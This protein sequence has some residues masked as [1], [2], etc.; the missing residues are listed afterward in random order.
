MTRRTKPDTLLL[1]IDV[2]TSTIKVGLYDTQGNVRGIRRFPQRIIRPEPCW[3][4]LDPS[5]WWRKICR[6]VKGLLQDEAIRSRK[7]AS[8]GLSGLCPCAMLLDDR[9]HAITPAIFHQD[10]RGLAIWRGLPRSTLNQAYRITGN[11][12]LPGTASVLSLLWFQE[13]S[14]AKFARAAAFGHATTLLGAKLTGTLGIDGSQA[15]LSGLFD[16]RAGVWS[17]E[18]CA[19]FGVE[20]RLLPPLLPA[21]ARLG[22]LSPEAARRLGLCDGIPVCIGGADTACAALGLGK[23]EPGDAFLLSGTTDVLGVVIGAPMPDPRL[24]LRPHVRPGAWLLLGVVSSAG[25]SLQWAK[26]TLRRSRAVPACGGERPL[27]LPHL[28][29]ERT[30]DCGAEAQGAFLGLRLETTPEDLW[31][32]VLEGTAMGLRQALERLESRAGKPLASLAYTGGGTANEQ[33]LQI[34]ADTL[35]RP[36]AVARHQEAALFGAALLGG[37]AAGVYRNEQ[38]LLAITRHAAPTTQIRPNPRQSRLLGRKYE[39][40]KQCYPR[41]RAVFSQ[42]SELSGLTSPMNDEVKR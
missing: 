9:G 29:G 26:R 34:K 39:V 28:A 30:G 19:A 23:A 40:F 17:E 4:E 37:L 2:G 10:R 35:G 32:A 1:G 21:G 18:L 20:R 42:L 14:R 25:A 38:E 33:W 31:T 41:L 22:Q 15:A 5:D 36:L 13:Y 3:A 7:V 27:F 6:G 16:L 12:L 8:I 24:I 11:T